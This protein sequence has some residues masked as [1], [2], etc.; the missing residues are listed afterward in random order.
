M[1]PWREYG[2]LL[3]WEW[4]VKARQVKEQEKKTYKML[5][6]QL[7]GKRWE[8]EKWAAKR[9][10]VKGN[11]NVFSEWNKWQKAFRKN[12]L[13][14]TEKGRRRDPKW[15]LRE[16]TGWQPARTACKTAS[17]IRLA[18]VHQAPKD[19]GEQQPS[20][21]CCLSFPVMI[22]CQRNKYTRFWLADYYA[23][24]HPSCDFW[25]H[26]QTDLMMWIYSSLNEVG[27]S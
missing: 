14:R 1:S 15:N 16:W 11:L 5:A 12:Q 26:M 24:S 4:A 3:N 19:K 8:A 17:S 23:K 9:S 21:I 18:N 13:L 27:F 7:W 22:S 10:R 6:K 2:S 20:T 25:P